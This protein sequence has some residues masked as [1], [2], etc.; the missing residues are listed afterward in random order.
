MNYKPHIQSIL[1]TLRLADVPHEVKHPLFELLAMLAEPDTLP[2]FFG[3]RLYKAASIL[4]DVP[5]EI[6]E[7]DVRLHYIRNEI[8]I[9]L[10][11][12]RGEV[13]CE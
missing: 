6:Y 5:L 4:A 1:E 12:R 10:A 13:E 8:E 7:H 2:G 9:L 11:C 3:H